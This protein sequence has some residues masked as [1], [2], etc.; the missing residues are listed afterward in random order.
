MGDSILHYTNLLL[1]A[2]SSSV[3][4]FT[5]L[6]G[7]WLAAKFSRTTLWISVAAVIGSIALR[8]YVHPHSLMGLSAMTALHIAGGCLV[9]LWLRRKF[10]YQDPATKQGD[11]V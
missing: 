1:T 9:G 7:V 5:F 8:S 3:F 6:I 10:K 11:S 2:A 4:T